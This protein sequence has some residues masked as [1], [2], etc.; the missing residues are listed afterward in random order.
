MPIDNS[1]NIDLEATSASGLAA[2]T[3]GD[4]Y[5]KFDIQFPS[6]IVDSK[7]ARI[8]QLLKKNAEETTE[9]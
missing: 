3:K 1:R 9:E 2:P 8:L 4:L 6:N 7:R 5:I